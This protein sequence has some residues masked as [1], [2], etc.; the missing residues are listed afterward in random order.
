MSDLL[1][2]NASPLERKVAAALAA[3]ENLPL[4][5]RSLWDTDTCPLGLLPYLAWALSVDEWDEA[6]SEA[7]KRTTVKESLLIHRRK[8]TLWSV[9]RVLA[10]QGFVATVQEGLTKLKRDGAGRHN[11]VY[12]HGGQTLWAVYRV[13]VT[14]RP[15]SNAEG[16]ALYRT[17]AAT[18][19]VRCRLQSIDFRSVP[20][21]HNGSIKRDGSYK[22]GSYSQ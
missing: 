21:K 4:P 1:P 2:P 13:T 7:Q 14:D 16:A 12:F 15:V 11:G 8:G 18:A 6:W 22:H 5:M 3:A 10:L 17:L 9:K 20:C 19:P